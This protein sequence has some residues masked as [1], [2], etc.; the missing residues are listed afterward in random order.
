MVHPDNQLWICPIIETSYNVS[1]NI[2]HRFWQQTG[3][4]IPKSVKVAV[5]MTVDQL[6]NF[7]QHIWECMKAL[8]KGTY[9]SE[10]TG[11]NNVLI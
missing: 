6:K 9:G 2:T 4:L 11:P 8:P 5:E 10:T 3:I 7:P 1:K